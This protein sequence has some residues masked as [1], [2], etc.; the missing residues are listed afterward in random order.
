MAIQRLLCIGLLALCALPAGAEDAAGTWNTSI[1]T[2]QG[3]LPLVI[4]LAVDGKKLT[5]TF[6]NHF[7]PKI[8]IQSGTVTG[9]QLAFTMTLVSATLA[10]KGVVEGDKLTLTHEVVEERDTKGGQSFGGAL[11]SADVLTATRAH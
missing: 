2:P 11:M 3:D 8:P 6:S 10:Y 7:M 5:G 1:R 9:N 4:E